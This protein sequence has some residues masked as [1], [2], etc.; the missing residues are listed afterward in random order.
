MPNPLEIEDMALSDVRQI[1]A[2]IERLREDN[3]DNAKIL[4]SVR[5]DMAHVI[6]SL[7][8]QSD[9]LDRIEKEKADRGELRDMDTRWERK[10][11]EVKASSA[12]EAG[13][14]SQEWASRLDTISAQITN[15]EEATKER[16]D[17]QD[18]A[19]KKHEDTIG[20]L[21]GWQN[22]VIG[23]KSGIAFVTGAF[24]GLLM[25]LLREF[26]K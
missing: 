22:R 24:G 26:I 6:E 3:L 12:F 1:L 11:N 20:R 23:W 16:F 5:S 2:A 13:R 9:K 15:Q 7:R 18:L 17:K 14:M 19:M 25:W 4:A 21:T 8:V 10:V